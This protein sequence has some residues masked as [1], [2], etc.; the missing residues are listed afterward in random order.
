MKFADIAGNSAVKHKLAATVDGG[1]V[2]HAWLFE[3]ADGNG[4]L[5]LA[6]AYGQYLCCP[7]K[8]NGDSCGT[9]PSCVKYQKLIH[10]DLHFVY[11]V[12]SSPKFSKP[13]SDDYIKEWRTFLA[14]TNYHDIDEWLN[15]LS[16]DN[17]Q[18]GIFAQESQNIIKKLNYKSFEAE[19]KVMVIWMPEKMNPSAS[20]KLLKM[21]EEPPAKTVFILVSN[22][23][24]S[25]L[26][27][28]QSRTQLVKI[29][30][31][32]AQSMFEALK[33]TYN[34]ADDKTKEIV[35]LA[36]GNFL[37]AKEVADSQADTVSEYFN[38]FADMMRHSY[39]MNVSELL[40]WADSVTK[41]GRERQKIFI[42]YALRLIREN[43]IL[44]ILPEKR[45][46][47]VYLTDKESAFAE[48]F[49]KFIHQKNINHITNEFNLAHKHIER[50][51]YEKLIFLDLA[52]KTAQLLAVKPQ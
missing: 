35:R 24:E 16:S 20:N 41:L 27:T 43:F 52:L 25:V 33:A 8:A 46:S 12:V 50:N 30:K 4:A 28:I 15:R 1:R 3:G 19:Y 45:E 26:K 10:P 23:A 5:A 9:C 32:D 42:D 36:D 14:E 48:K 7:K 31:I 38:L 47:L 44:T 6:V 22:H 11:P 29:P 34:F 37:R 49:H 51:G 39:T 40:D 2:S 17:K 18:A 21:I 13:V